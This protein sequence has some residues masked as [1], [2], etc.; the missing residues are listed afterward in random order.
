MTDLSQEQT[1]KNE[2]DAAKTSPPSRS[3]LDSVQFPEFSSS[4][5]EVDSK[6]NAAVDVLIQQGEELN[7]LVVNYFLDA[8]LF[9]ALPA[10]IRNDKAQLEAYISSTSRFKE[11]V[12]TERAARARG[13]K[14]GLLGEEVKIEES[15]HADGRVRRAESG[16]RLH[17]DSLKAKGIDPAKVLFFRLTQPGDSPKP[18]YYWTS[19]Y[20]ET[21]TGLNA[22]VGIEQ[23]GSA[24]VLVSDLATINGNGGLIQDI[25]DDSGIAVRQINPGPFDQKTALATIRPKIFDKLTTVQAELKGLHKV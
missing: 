7:P 24:V 6:V 11:I 13:Q 16:Y 9:E 23:R 10:E 3:L 19:D 22:E 5:P 14:D 17:I 4:N 21:T 18:E 20:F 15:T 2:K 1:P 8:D 12:G 25:N